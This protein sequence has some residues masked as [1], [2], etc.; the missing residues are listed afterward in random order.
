MF[1]K[2][3]LATVAT[4]CLCGSAA[5]D[6]YNFYLH[7]KSDGWVISGFQTLHNGRWSRNWLDR[8][9]PSGRSEPMVW[10]SQ[11]GDCKVSF[12]VNWVDYGSET[13]SMDWCKNNPTNVYMKNQG[14][15]W[16]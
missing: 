13:F 2:M 9:I 5:A 8:R 4:L 3:A 7:N 15:T 10:N 6:N 14:F 1:K 11:S 12:R 16:D